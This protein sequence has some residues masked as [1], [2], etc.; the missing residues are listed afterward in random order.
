MGFDLSPFCL[1]IAVTKPCLSF[2]EIYPSKDF[3][4]RTARG[5]ARTSTQFFKRDTEIPS[6]P[7]EADVGDALILFIISSSVIS[8]SSIHLG[9]GVLISASIS[10][11]HDGSRL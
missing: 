4:Y 5:P 6:G 10:A 7:E 2:V 3:R 1:N 9:P 11:W 8:K